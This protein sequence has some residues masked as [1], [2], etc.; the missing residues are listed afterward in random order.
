MTESE[1][2]EK[3]KE[4]GCTDLK[5]DYELKGTSVWTGLVLTPEEKKRR[6]EEKLAKIKEDEELKKTSFDFGKYRGETYE[7]ISIKD[8]DYFLWAYDNKWEDDIVI[9]G[10]DKT[11]L[12]VERARVEKEIEDKKDSLIADAKEK[13]EI[14]L[15]IL[16]NPRQ[17]EHHTERFPFAS[18]TEEGILVFFED[19]KETS[20][21][22]YDYLTPLVKGKG[23]RV[24]GKTFKIIIDPA[25][26]GRG[27]LCLDIKKVS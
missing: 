4:L 16:G 12:M 10:M 26:E 22:G 14:T 7:A 15:T 1:A 24:K 8:K 27:V 17:E 5:P 20:Y 18:K 19:V 11:T 25:Y 13:G 23:K 3:A 6:E 9:A 21:G 2:I